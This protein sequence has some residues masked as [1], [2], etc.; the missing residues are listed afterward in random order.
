M[1]SRYSITEENIDGVKYSVVEFKKVFL[2]PQRSGTLEID[3]L[4]IDCVVRTENKRRR[5]FFDPNY[6]DNVYSRKGNGLKIEVIPLPEQG[7][8]KD[9]SGA[10]GNFTFKAQL[11]KEKVKTNDAINLNITISGKGNIKLIQPMKLNIPQDI[12]T[13]DPKLSENINAT[14]TGVAGSKSYEYVLIPRN[15]APIKSGRS[16]SVILIRIKKPTS[17]CRLLNLPLLL[18]KAQAI[19][20]KPP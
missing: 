12:E 14:A 2:F 17:I 8:P 7:K 5:S 11:N 13:Y 9:F 3:P 15:P 18:K 19:I 10:V 16:I 20:I 4:E 1:P 6:E